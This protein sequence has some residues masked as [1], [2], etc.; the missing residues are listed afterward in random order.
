MRTKYVEENAPTATARPQIVSKTQTKTNP[1]CA[2]RKLLAA[3]RQHAEDS[4]HPASLFI[5]TMAL[6]LSL[7]GCKS[8]PPFGIVPLGE[9]EAYRQ[10]TVNAL[11]GSECSEWS[12]QVLRRY[13]LEAQ[14]QD[15]PLEALRALHDTTQRDDRRDLF[16]TLA[17]LCYLAANSPEPASRLDRA[18]ILQLN[19]SS[20]IYAYAYLLGKGAGQPPTAFDR[21]FRVACDLYNYALG[22]AFE[23]DNGRLAI[24]TGTTRAWLGG[25]LNIALD[26]R[27]FLA[28]IADYD[29]AVATGR[30]G[31]RGMEKRHRNSGLGAPF[32]AM[33]RASRDLPAPFG[34]SG[35]LFLSITEAGIPDFVDGTLSG[36]LRFVSDLNQDHV[37][38]AGR[39]IPLEINPTMAVAYT[40]EG[41]RLWDMGWDM[42]KSGESVAASRLYTADPGRTGRIPVIFVH[43]TWSTF[44]P[45]I[46]MWNALRTDPKLARK[47]QYWFFLYDTGKPVVF[48][49]L[50]LRAAITGMIKRL[51]P[52]GKDPALHRAVVIGHSQGGLLTRFIATDTGEQL[53]KA[54]TGLGL[55]DL[56]VSDDE[57]ALIRRHTIFEAVPDVKRVIY[58]ATPH[59]GVFIAGRPL[60]QRWAVKAVTIPEEMRTTLRTLRRIA[61]AHGV[62][63]VLDTHL[64]TSMNSM[65]PHNAAMATL[66][67]I[68]TA[69]GI[70]AHSI[71]PEEGDGPLE[72]R[73]DGVVPYTSSHLDGVESE[74]I[75]P[76]THTACLYHPL[77]IEEVRR[78]LLEHLDT[79]KE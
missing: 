21:R 55:D 17:E 10:D 67:K 35:T 20:C 72:K 7:P 32:V 77:T 14:Y 29:Y 58:V 8:L 39:D 76:S 59:R 49:A 6:M 37:R 3:C 62:A 47:Y 13:N 52:D 69:P 54:A 43:G 65:S 66:A 38:E 73:S 26:D 40:M 78:I 71:I 11:A 64:R 56:H 16:Y 50:R 30:F 2:Q 34:V 61:R 31:L 45:W 51:D 63:E 79:A 4:R 46:E 27:A 75:V 9:C 1:V 48:S 24:E 68:P 70:H 42:F 23:D 18:T 33:R 25:T 74:F 60:P 15:A 36:T 57:R 19:L 41:S 44:S 12:T 53:L 5:L 22:Q 28:P